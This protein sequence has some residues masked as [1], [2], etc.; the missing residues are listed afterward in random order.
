M[1]KSKIVRNVL[2]VIAI[3]FIATVL[4]GAGCSNVAGGSSG[5]GGGNVAGGSGG[6][7]SGSGGGLNAA[8]KMIAGK[9]FESGGKKLYFGSN[10]KGTLTGGSSPN[11]RSISGG[12]FDWSATNGTGSNINITMTNSGGTSSAVFDGSTKLTVDGTAYTLQGTLNGVPS[13]GSIIMKDGSLKTKDNIGSDKANAIAVVYYVDTANRKAYAVG[14]NHYLANN[15]QYW[16]TPAASVANTVIS[17]LETTVGGAAPNNL[18]FD[19]YKDGSTGLAILK[20][21]AS[22]YNAAKYPAW[23]WCETYGNTASNVPSDAVADFKT[24]WY[25]PSVKELYDIWK[26]QTTVDAA[27]QAVDGEKFDGFHISSSTDSAQCWYLSFIDLSGY[28]IVA[29]NAYKN[30]KSDRTAV[31]VCAV[32]V[33][34]Y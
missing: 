34:T 4:S 13:V 8:E 6:N 9:T 11:I 12:D 26:Q 29:G 33:F 15:G 28:G 3:V 18:T 20:A 2:A 31:R 7:P 24:G 27:L 10:K 5:G 21:A 30:D 19:G 32:R 16:C 25:F 23:A 14:K 1:K 22:D 17:G